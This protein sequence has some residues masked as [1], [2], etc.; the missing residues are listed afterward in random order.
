MPRTFLSGTLARRTACEMGEQRTELA[1][2]DMLNV[3]G[4]DIDTTAVMTSKA[5]PERVGGS[6]KSVKV[7]VS[8]SYGR[9][10]LWKTRC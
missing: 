5:T 7:S 8:R 6:E 2:Q 3:V 9:T 4:G 10:N 1:T